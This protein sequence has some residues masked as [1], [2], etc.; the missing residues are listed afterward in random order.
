[1]TSS[2]HRPTGRTGSAANTPGNDARSRLR[3]R[4]AQS[5]SGHLE[6]PPVRGDRPDFL[7]HLTTQPTQ[8]GIRPPTGRERRERHQRFRALRALGVALAVAAV[9]AVVALAV[10]LVLRESS[11][12]EIQTIEVEATDHVSLEDIQNLVQV[13]E[14]ATLLNVDT[15][16]ITE[17]LMQDSWVASVSY[18]YVWPH[19]L[20]ITVVEQEVWALVVMSSGSI[21]WY[22]GDAGI[23]IQPVKLVASGDQTVDDAGLALALEEGV[24]L[25]TDVPSS[26]SPSAGEEATDDVLEAVATFQDGFSTSFSSQIVCYYAPSTDSI[27]CVLSS[28]VEVLL[29]SASDIDEKEAIATEILDEYEG[30]V[31]YINV[32][33][34]T[35][36][37]SSFRLIDSD[38]VTAGSGATV[39]TTTSDDDDTASTDVEDEG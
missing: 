4:P 5:F 26:V 16:A 15:D 34:P 39:S 30:L 1:M 18:E 23:W 2:S 20:K 6:A 14:G 17:S 11:V 19:T 21:A 31:T 32:R 25:I 35:S 9:L 37:G 12:F 38:S 3:S 36:T 24:V 13:E 22:L 7:S 28:G 27:S 8:E 10:Y 33:N 29:G